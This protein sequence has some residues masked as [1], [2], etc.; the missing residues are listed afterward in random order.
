MSQRSAAISVVVAASAV[1]GLARLVTRR[2]SPQALQPAVVDVASA[3]IRQFPTALDY[4]P[5]PSERVTVEPNPTTVAPYQR[6]LV[7]RVDCDALL[8]EIKARESKLVCRVDF[9]EILKDS[10]MRPSQPLEMDSVFDRILIDA[11]KGHAQQ[12]LE[13]GK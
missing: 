12:V 11:L 10:K 9:D 3:R 1:A 6:A 5:S 13:G 2:A 4:P 7:C 8:K